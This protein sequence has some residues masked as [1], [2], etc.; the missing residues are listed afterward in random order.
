MVP[1]NL[2]RDIKRWAISYRVVRDF[3]LNYIW[4]L[5]SRIFLLILFNKYVARLL[6][7]TC[8][9]HR[10]SWNENLLL[11]YIT[12]KKP[13]L[14]QFNHDNDNS[15]TIILSCQWYRTW[16]E[17]CNQLCKRS[18]YIRWRSGKKNRGALCL[19][20][21]RALSFASS[22]ACTIGYKLGWLS[23]SL[24]RHHVHLI[25][26]SCK[27]GPSFRIAQRR[28]TGLVNA[29]HGALFG[30]DFINNRD[31]VGPRWTGARTCLEK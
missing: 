2:F 12:L 5:E 1:V 17:I 21:F 18:S 11:N 16:I 3:I 24:A 7:D 23:A 28:D 26:C 8:S 19:D 30:T 6:L 15:I 22:K 29:Q 10:W 14:K 9:K 20:H 4:W 13:I 27:S 25:C 31:H